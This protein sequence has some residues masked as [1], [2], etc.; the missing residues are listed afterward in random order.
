[1]EWLFHGCILERFSGVTVGRGLDAGA[2]VGK[3]VVRRRLEAIKR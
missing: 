2:G 1:M 3:S